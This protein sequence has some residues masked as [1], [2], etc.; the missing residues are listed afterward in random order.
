MDELVTTLPCYF[1][2]MLSE[3]S[4]CV[5]V[6]MCVCACVCGHNMAHIN[7]EK[8]LIYIIITYCIKIKSL[9]IERVRSRPSATVVT[10][11]M[12][13]FPLDGHIYCYY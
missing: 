7:I 6:C 10:M 3:Y 8:R 4:L 5:C 13:N 2:I 11:A 1:Y 12:L 9:G